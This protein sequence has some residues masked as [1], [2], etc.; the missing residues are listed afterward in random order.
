[1]AGVSLP[2]RDSPGEV[3][4]AVEKP[5]LLLWSENHVLAITDHSDQR[6]VLAV[7]FIRLEF[8]GALRRARH[9]LISSR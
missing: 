5:L 9:S 8:A 1:M 3:R 7:G 4:G 6:L 2:S